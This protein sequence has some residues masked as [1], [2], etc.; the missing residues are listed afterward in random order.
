MHYNSEDQLSSLNLFLSKV[1]SQCFGD[2]CPHMWFLTHACES[3]SSEPSV[4][5]TVTS[6]VLMQVAFKSHSPNPLLHS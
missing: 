2:S 5:H 1:S 3:I 4:A 6:P